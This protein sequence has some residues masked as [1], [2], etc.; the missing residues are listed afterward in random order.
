MFDMPDIELCGRINIGKG[1][2]GETGPQGPPGRDGRDG[3]D[4]TV[5]FDDLSQSQKDQ[6]KGDQ[7]ERGPEGPTGPKGDQGPTGPTGEQGEPGPRGPIGEVGPPGPVGPQ[8]LKGDGIRIKTVV[9]TEDQIEEHANHNN[10]IG[11]CIFVRTGNK[12]FIWDAHKG[13]SGG[14]NEMGSFKGAEG[15]QGPTGPAGA[16]GPKGPNGEVGPRGP[17]GP[18]GPPGPRGERGLR[19]ETGP[20]GET[21]PPLDSTLYYNRVESD[22]RF[23]HKEN[24]KFI[25]TPHNNLDYDKMVI[26]QPYDFTPT[27]FNYNH[28]NKND[29]IVINVDNYSPHETLLVHAFVVNKSHEFL[30]T[31]IIGKTKI[32][33]APNGGPLGKDD[34]IYKEFNNKNINSD[35]WATKDGFYKTNG[36]T[37]GTFPGDT[38]DGILEVVNQWQ[39]RIIQTWTGTSDITQRKYIR[40]KQQN[41]DW[42]R[43]Y[44]SAY[45]HEYD[46]FRNNDFNNLKNKVDNDIYTKRDVYDKSHIDAFYYDKHEYRMESFQTGGHAGDNGYADIIPGRLRIQW[47]YINDAGNGNEHRAIFD[48][49]RRLYTWNIT[50]HSNIWGEAT[51]LVTHKYGDIDIGIKAIWRK[52]GVSALMVG[53]GNPK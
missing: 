3:V 10:Q 16:V 28:V 29:N 51:P 24:I 19:G 4:G 20:K 44:T 53:I 50:S 40:V 42:G 43:W 5:D 17:S 11:D 21:G 39:G 27:H 23:A 22:E 52:G 33:K 32:L 9:D 48:K 41:R 31:K 37:Q 38:K 6:L 45:A 46:N 36:Q 12:L 7:G 8:G 15:P 14:W 35:T 1:E 47:K 13:P 25:A 34:S 30:K 26:G 2:K 18:S 49:L